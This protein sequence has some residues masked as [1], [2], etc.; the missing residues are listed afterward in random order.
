LSRKITRVFDNI[1]KF[2]CCPYAYEKEKFLSFKLYSIKT[3]MQTS[4]I[5]IN[6]RNESMNDL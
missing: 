3:S 6:Y 5:N 2:L 4:R 1:T